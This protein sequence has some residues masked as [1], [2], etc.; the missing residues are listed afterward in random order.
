MSEKRPPYLKLPQDFFDLSASAAVGAVTLLVYL[1]IRRYVWRSGQRRGDFQPKPSQVVAYVN[2]SALGGAVGVNRQNVSLHIG[3]LEKLGWLHRLNTN[4][5]KTERV[6]EVGFRSKKGVGEDAEV[7]F[8]DQRLAAFRKEVGGE[9]LKT[10]NAEAK[11]EALR[12]FSEAPLVSSARQGLSHQQDT[13]IEKAGIA[14]EG[15]AKEGNRCAEPPLTRRRHARFA[16]ARRLRRKTRSA[17]GTAGKDHHP[18]FRAP[19][20]STTRLKT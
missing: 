15:I 8:A 11:G 10:M 18:Q 6:Y 17:T 2:Q 3:K 1:H 16:R 14:K 20:S 5:D 19:P 13:R 4:G 12:D 9:A 7:Y